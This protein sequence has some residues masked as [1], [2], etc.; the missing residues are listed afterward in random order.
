MSSKIANEVKNTLIEIGT[1]D[2]S[3][4]RT[5]S[6]NTVLNSGGCVVHAAGIYGPGRN[7]VNWVISGRVG[8]SAKY[9]NWIHVED[10]AGSLIA[11]A[12]SQLKG[13]RLIASDNQALQWSEICEKFAEKLNFEIK[14]LNYQS[15]RQS[16]QISHSSFEKINYKLKHP[17]FIEEAI[18]LY[19][20][21][22]T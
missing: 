17:K 4:E 15:K 6:E 12:E 7:P 22:T 1:R 14:N 19:K 13:E 10:L 2:P 20:Q 8:P 5:S 21:E 9:V 16:K 18:K 3:N 11:C